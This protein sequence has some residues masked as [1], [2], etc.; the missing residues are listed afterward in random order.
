MPAFGLVHPDRLDP[1]TF[2]ELDQL[3]AGVQTAFQQLG[4]SVDVTF[5]A[6]DFTANGSM[7]WTVA[8]Q[9]V[10]TFAWTLIGKRMFVDWILLTTTIGGTVNSTLQIKIPGG[11]TARRQT[12]ASTFATNG[13]VRISADAVVQKNGVVI[14]IF[15]RDLANWTAGAV[16][17]VQGQIS[18]EVI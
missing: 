4:R 1:A 15:R 17:D 3:T 7:T 9:N 2:D 13:G 12:F 16:E 8:K 6:G 10:N 11:Y 14:Q 18:F 5:F